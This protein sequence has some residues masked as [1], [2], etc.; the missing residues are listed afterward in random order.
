MA[1]ITSSKGQEHL[2]TNTFT[3][4]LFW[5]RLLGNGPS[6]SG[7]SRRFG[8][9]FSYLGGGSLDSRG[10]LWGLLPSPPFLFNILLT[11]RILT[12]SK[13]MRSRSCEMWGQPGITALPLYPQ[14]CRLLWSACPPGS[15]L[16]SSLLT[17]SS[18]HLFFYFCKDKA[19][20]CRLKGCLLVSVL[21]LPQLHLWCSFGIRRTRV[22]FV[23]FV[24]CVDS[25]LCKWI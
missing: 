2:L 23:T 24:V 20:V 17:S 9:G 25:F 21:R 7:R 10:L 12:F 16:S 5:G 22:S 8:L 3:S 4:A 14:P 6:R 1:E 11:V 15:G 13:M 18:T 19:G